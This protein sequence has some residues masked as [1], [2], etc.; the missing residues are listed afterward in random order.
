MEC[1]SIDQ[2]GNLETAAAAAAAAAANDSA[3]SVTP[4]P[5]ATPTSRPHKQQL[6]QQ[7]VLPSDSKSQ[8]PSPAMPVV[9][10]SP[11][12]VVF[13]PPL[14]LPASDTHAPTRSEGGGS[15][16][17]GEEKV[18]VP[19]I[20]EGARSL[21]SMGEEDML[22]FDD[23]REGTQSVV[24]EGD[25]GA[26]LTQALAGPQLKER[27]LEFILP[28][29]TVQEFFEDYISDKASRGVDKYHGMEKGGGEYDIERG[30]ASSK[31]IEEEDDIF[32]A[33]NYFLPIL[34]LIS[35]HS[36]WEG[37]TQI[38]VTPWQEVNQ[39]VGATRTIHFVT[40]LEVGI[41]RRHA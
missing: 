1:R 32:A 12:L 38:E 22:D 10:T 8:A 18:P 6:Q 35:S 41:R 31:Q 36:E 23:L 17:S 14:E 5:S 25:L 19:P 39:G 9:P 7:P 27:G 28:K 20:L 2:A 13:P 21:G 11:G 30:E 29:V 15:P 4:I 26:A 16:E 40:S 24:S 3:A 33:S 34:S 37:D